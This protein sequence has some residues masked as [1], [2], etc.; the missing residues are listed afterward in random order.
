MYWLDVEEGLVVT[1]GVL[2]ADYVGDLFGG[3]A[4]PEP[5][6]YYLSDTVAGA[7]TLT[8]TAGCRVAW[9]HQQVTL[10]QCPQGTSKKFRL[11]MGGRRI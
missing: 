3:D 1:G 10:V 4:T 6:V 9:F 11:P 8:R 2:D 5:G 7:V